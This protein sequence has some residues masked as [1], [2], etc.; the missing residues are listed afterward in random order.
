MSR[1]LYRA[2]SYKFV[3]YIHGLSI[4]APNPLLQVKSSL[5]EEI[6]QLDRQLSEQKQKNKELVTEKVLTVLTYMSGMKITV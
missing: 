4:S 6:V 2:I 3:V 5:S 1:H